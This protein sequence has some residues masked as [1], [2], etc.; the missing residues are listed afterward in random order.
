MTL[1]LSKSIIISVLHA[2]D[3]MLLCRIVTSVQVEVQVGAMSFFIIYLEPDGLAEL[4]SEADGLPYP[5]VTCYRFVVIDLW[6]CFQILAGRGRPHGL[7]RRENEFVAFVLT[8]DLC[9]TYGQ[10]PACISFAYTPGH[11]NRHN[12]VTGVPQF[13]PTVPASHTPVNGTLGCLWDGQS[14]QTACGTTRCPRW[15]I[16]PLMRFQN[17]PP[18]WSPPHPANLGRVRSPMPPGGSGIPRTHPVPGRVHCPVANPV[19]PPGAAGI[20]KPP[21]LSIPVATVDNAASGIRVCLPP[22]SRAGLPPELGRTGRLAAGS[23]RCRGGT[24]FLSSRMVSPNGVLTAGSRKPGRTARQKTTVLLS[25]SDS[26]K[27]YKSVYILD[28]IGLMDFF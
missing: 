2:L 16:S 21:R 28:A 9:D 20:L 18:A 8:C 26:R 22:R 25:R 11:G 15:L 5:D 12:P 23:A 24:D 27:F 10:I 3:T 1:F 4:P 7:A 17:M 13:W 14:R 19:L 6:K